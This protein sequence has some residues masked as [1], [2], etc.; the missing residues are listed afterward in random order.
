MREFQLSV[1]ASLA[2]LAFYLC[3][4]GEWEMAKEAVKK[5]TIKIL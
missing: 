5:W 2:C 3:E 1:F 4:K